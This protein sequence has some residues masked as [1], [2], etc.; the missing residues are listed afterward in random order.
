M[1]NIAL[2]SDNKNS[3]NN[4]LDKI[5]RSDN[6]NFI[7]ITS[8]IDTCSHHFDSFILLDFKNKTEIQNLIGYVVIN[9]KQQ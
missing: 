8:S 9:Y 6:I 4:F 3:I 5:V 2:I 7:P 1:I